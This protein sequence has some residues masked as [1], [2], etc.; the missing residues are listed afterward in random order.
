MGRR[1]AD[2]TAL[3]GG[4]HSSQLLLPVSDDGVDGCV[5]PCNS[6][7]VLHVVWCGQPLRDGKAQSCSLAEELEGHSDSIC[8]AVCVL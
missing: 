5:Q 6:R 4:L 1:V 2:L 7:V 3:R 8:N